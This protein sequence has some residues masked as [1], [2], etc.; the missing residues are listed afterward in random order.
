MGELSSND[1][2]VFFLGLA[3][4]LGLAHAFGEVAR[5]LGQPAVIGE[6]AAGLLLGPT[7]LGVAIPR[8]QA[9]LFPA[10]GPAAVALDAVVALAVALLLL[11]AGMEVDL[12]ALWR[13]GRAGLAIA[14]A[15]VTV[16]L[17][18]GG[19]LAWS[20][21]GW[22]GIPTEE[23][24]TLFAVFF[25]TALAVSAL[26]VIAKI[27]LD[28]DLFRTD[29]G[30]LVLVAATVNNLLTWLVFS[31]VLG[32][33]AGM[34]SIG[35]TVALTFGFV[36][37][38]L[39]LGR[40]AADRAMPW[41][42]AHLPWPGGILGFLLVTGLVGAAMTEAIGIHA[43]FGAFLAG[44]ALGDSPHLREHTRQIL[45]RFVDGVLAP[46]FVASI[47]LEVNFVEEFQ[48]GLVL[49][50]LIVGIAVKLVGCGLA[51]RAGG[52]RGAEAWGVGWAM[53]A[54]GTL[55]IVLGLLAWHA[56]VIRERLFVA[57]VTLALVTTAMAGPMIKRLLR[58]ERVWSLAAALDGRLCRVDLEAADAADAIRMLSALA[59]ERAVLSPDWVT[60]EVLRREA[61]MSTGIGRGVAV[62]HA[63][64][65]NLE[66]P[67]AVAGLF[68]SGLDFDAPDGEPVHLV[69]LILTPRSDAGA[70]VQILAS[71]ARLLRDPQV[72][73]EALS[74]RTP[75]ALLAALRI[76]DAIH[77]SRP[78]GDR[79]PAE[80]LPAADSVS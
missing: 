58:R 78:H 53:N 44:I 52:L 45:R 30:M 3:T 17:V 79:P 50:V 64:M 34:H 27:L 28:L 65:I 33:R 18:V 37:L 68:R 59:A 77:H 47:G 42:Q 62:P 23:M 48:P 38:I 73:Q 54:R 56:G 76:A 8:F 7:V 63:R 2:T 1:L 11:V 70:Q 12:S 21:P 49:R 26:P 29:F 36:V 5:R 24:P 4:L 40:W 51:A 46:V 43:I 9:W 16:P 10:T 67:L 35:Y 39:T 19:L 15:G 66:E 61:T 22:W 13:Q 72:R 69:F 31:V 55:G 75:T 25:G 6:M 74:A 41:L 71:I 60:E 80:I 14:L 57:L 32:G 20:M